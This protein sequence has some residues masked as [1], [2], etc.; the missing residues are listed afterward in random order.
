MEEQNVLSLLAV[1]K[2]SAQIA[3]QSYFCSAVKLY[4]T[5]LAFSFILPESSDK[6]VWQ[7]VLLM[8]TSSDNIWTVI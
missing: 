3:G 5:S 7:A 2:R 8:F 6:I 4:G 1:F